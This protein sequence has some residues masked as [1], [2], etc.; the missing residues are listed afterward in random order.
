MEIL[1]PGDDPE[2]AFFA[3]DAEAVDA[4]YRVNFIGSLLPSQIFGRDMLDRVDFA[5]YSGV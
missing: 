1:H 4:T 5:A 3:L 2:A